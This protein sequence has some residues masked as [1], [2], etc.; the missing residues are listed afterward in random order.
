MSRHPDALQI[1]GRPRLRDRLDGA[2]GGGHA[3][4]G[5]FETAHFDGNPA[6]LVEKFLS[7]GGAD[8]RTVN[9]CED[10]LGPVQLGDSFLRLFAFAGVVIR[11]CRRL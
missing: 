8:N 9:S 3:N 1:P 7:V 11:R 10:C 4:P 5:E 6:N 2:V